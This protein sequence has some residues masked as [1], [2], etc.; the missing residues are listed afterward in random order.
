MTTETVLYC[1]APLC[2]ERLTISVGYHRSARGRAKRRGWV[3]A[4]INGRKSDY[5]P[6]HS[7]L[8]TNA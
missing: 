7:N 6:A 2:E 5:C 1:D 8:R 3:D 4:L